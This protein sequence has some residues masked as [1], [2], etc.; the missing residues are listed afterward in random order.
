[1]NAISMKNTCRPQLLSK[2]VLVFFTKFIQYVRL[3][4]IEI[5][6]YVAMQCDAMHLKSDRVLIS[7]TVSLALGSTIR[8]QLCWWIKINIPMNCCPIASPSP[9]PSLGS[10]RIFAFIIIHTSA[11]VY[12]IFSVSNWKAMDLNLLLM[13]VQRTYYY[14]STHMLQCQNGKMYWQSNPIRG[15]MIVWAGIPNALRSYHIRIYLWPYKPG[16]DDLSWNFG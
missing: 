16:H 9:S 6:W 15:L 5:P 14:Y 10:M 13:Y 3:K 11:F 2:L 4:T 8:R 12:G 7:T 1:M